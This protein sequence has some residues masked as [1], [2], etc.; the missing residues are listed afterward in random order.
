[1]KL[2]T[3]VKGATKRWKLKVLQVAQLHCNVFRQ[4]D[5]KKDWSNIQPITYTKKLG[6]H[7]EISGE[8]I[9]ECFTQVSSEKSN[10]E[11]KKTWISGQVFRFFAYSRF[12][13]W[14]WNKKNCKT[15]ESS[16]CI[17][18]SIRRVKEEFKAVLF[19]NVALECVCIDSNLPVFTTEIQKNDFQN[20][21]IEN[22]D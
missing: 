10:F 14:N 17:F 11:N 9:S 1:M 6:I 22:N 20:N 5:W 8:T 12:Q 18:L 16:N 15:N 2:K 13:K 7:T 4:E 19:K 3:K 21:Y